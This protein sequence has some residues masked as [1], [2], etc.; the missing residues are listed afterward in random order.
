MLLCDTGVLQN[1]GF[2]VR[3]YG[4]DD[5]GKILPYSLLNTRK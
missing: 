5:I 3:T 2:R 4:R 1:L